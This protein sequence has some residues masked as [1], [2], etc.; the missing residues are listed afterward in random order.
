MGPI[1]TAADLRRVAIIAGCLA[2]AG[3]VA[4]VAV[5]RP[6]TGLFLVVGF[7]LG[8]LNA[9]LL[10]RAAGQFASADGGGKRRFALG[11][12]GRLAVITAAALAI[13][14]LV[15]PAGVGV[16]IGL[17]LFQLLLVGVA[18][19]PLL[20]DLRQAGTEE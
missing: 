18:L 6:L 14:V 8:M 17:A 9:L 13:G 16:F 1:S 2:A 15:Q 19:V 4:L 10:R 20:K 12:L 5:G 11:A 7:G 3:V